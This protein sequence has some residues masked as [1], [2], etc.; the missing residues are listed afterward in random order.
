MAQ[1]CR[2]EAGQRD[3]AW[4]SW[5]LVACSALVLSG[6]FERHEPANPF[7]GPNGSSEEGPFGMRSPASQTRRAMVPEAAPALAP[8]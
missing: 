8:E 2:Q 1:G 7:I 3:L 4:M 5:L 6:C